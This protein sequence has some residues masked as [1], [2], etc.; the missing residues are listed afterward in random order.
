MVFFLITHYLVPHNTF[1]EW[2]G[3]WT[4]KQAEQTRWVGEE[5]EGRMNKAREDPGESSPAPQH[6]HTQAERLKWGWND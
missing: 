5:Q 6:L 3:L 2:F 4:G 1:N